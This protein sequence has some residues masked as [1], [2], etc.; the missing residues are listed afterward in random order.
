MHFD[1][2]YTAATKSK[3]LVPWGLLY[4][5]VYRYRECFQNKMMLLVAKR[6]KLHGLRNAAI[7]GSSLYR[8]PASWYT[9]HGIKSQH[10]H[11]P[12]LGDGKLF[13]SL[14]LVNSH[15]HSGR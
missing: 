14:A 13:I 1:R 10:P 3:K 8:N 11:S 5:D 4:M 2:E 9:P 15:R 7:K 6:L 12:L